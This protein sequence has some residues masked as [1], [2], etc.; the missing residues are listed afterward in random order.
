MVDY[1]LW[2]VIENGNA[3]P[4][5]QVFEGFKTTIDD[6]TAEEKAQR[7]LEWKA[8]STLLMRIPN[9]HQLK[10]N[11]IKDAKSL[12]QAVEKRDGFKVADGYANN[13]GKDILKE[14]WK[15]VVYEWHKKSTRGTV[16]V[17]TPVSSSLV[18]CDRLGGL[19]SVEAR[20][21]VYKKNESI[22]E[23]GIK[24]LKRN[25][26]PL[27]PDLS[28]L[29]EFAIE[30]KVSEP[31]VK[32]P[33]VETSEPKASTDNPKVII[34]K[35]MKDMLPLEVTQEEGKS[36]AESSQDD[37]FQ[38]SSDDGKKVDEDQRQESKRK[39][40][41][42]EDN[43]KNTNNVNDAGTNRVNAVAANTNNELSF[44]PEMPALEILAHLT[45]QVIMKTMM[46]RLT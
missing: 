12:L 26:L 23:E 32:K 29:E 25:F 11:S 45:S 7:R 5:T 27:K 10:F 15:E 40:Q 28:C 13:E 38:P 46:N 18:S 31:T 1:S 16:P 21:L 33:I 41:E 8:R 22:Y 20:L 14:H 44:D 4:I 6:A 35:L 37:I 36:Q 34:K 30:S 9:E 17:E 39:D 42:K 2:K 24:L 43:V 3:P 19:E